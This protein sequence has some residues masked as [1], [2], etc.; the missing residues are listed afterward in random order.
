MSESNTLILSDGAVFKT[1]ED[2]S[3]L[4]SKCL[5]SGFNRLVRDRT[6]GLITGIFNP[7]ATIFRPFVGTRMKAITALTTPCRNWRIAGESNTV[8][9]FDVSL[10]SRQLPTVQCCDPKLNKCESCRLGYGFLYNLLDRTALRI[11]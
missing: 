10:F 11:L 3:P 6:S 8:T 9:P 5:P 1:V 7:T 2:R 4:F